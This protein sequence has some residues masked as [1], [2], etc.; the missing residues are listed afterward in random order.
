MCLI[1][2]SKEIIAEEDVI[3]YKL[4]TQTINLVASSALHGK[5]FS[6]IINNKECHGIVS[7][8]DN[9]VYLCNNTSIDSFDC[10]EQFGYKY[11]WL[12]DEAV[13]N[14]IIDEISCNEVKYSSPYMYTPIE[15][16]TVY[17]GKVCV[18]DIFGSTFKYIEEGFHTYSVL[19]EAIRNKQWY[20]LIFEAVIPKGAKY[21]NGTTYQFQSRASDRIVYTKILD[22]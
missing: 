18:L 19:D 5:P 14:L 12:L 7:I 22:V 20:N 3:C 2:I 15:L 9:D 16:N 4:V 11:G 17:E 21:Y 1:H 8:H 10:P 6:A 13:R